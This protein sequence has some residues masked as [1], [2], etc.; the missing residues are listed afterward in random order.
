MR[1]ALQQQVVVDVDKPVSADGVVLHFVHPQPEWC[2]RREP[3][4]TD[5]GKVIVASQRHTKR[6][7]RARGNDV[8]RDA[9]THPRFERVDGEAGLAQCR[10]K[11]AVLFETVAATP[12]QNEFLL[13]RGIVEEGYPPSQ[14]LDVLEWDRRRMPL[15]QP[16]Q[17]LQRRRDRA[18]ECDAAL[19]GVE[20]DGGVGHGDPGC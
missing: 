14:H 7:V 4:E 9:G 1:L 3:A 11:E 18:V 5:V 16:R 20:I 12:V 19:V 10:E 6:H 17:R 2:R 8:G 15:D 13:E